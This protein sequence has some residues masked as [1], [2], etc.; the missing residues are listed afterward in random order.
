M[1]TVYLHHP[2]TMIVAGPTGCGKTEWIKRLITNKNN[3]IYPI[4]NDIFYF[5][6]EYQ[7]IFNQIQGVKFIH[8]LNFDEI[9]NLDS[10]KPKLFIID[11]LMDDAAN[12]NSVSH[13]F[14]KGSHHRNISVIL[15]VQNF[16]ARGKVMRNLSLNTHYLVLFKNP[17]DKMISMNIARQM[18]P[19][20]I[21]RFY[22]IFNE[23]TKD[24]YS[25][26]FIDLK[27][28]TPEEIRL[29]SN[30]LGEKKFISAYKII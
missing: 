25:Y 26:L 13:L 10:N 22:E 18:Y 8:G 12:S 14:T 6:G 29:L 2:F 15:I 9:E 20:K 5:Y 16:F 23:A 30:V 27:S 7:S 3:I 28:N 1:Y 11:D 17:R 21:K 24:P 19:S 4:P